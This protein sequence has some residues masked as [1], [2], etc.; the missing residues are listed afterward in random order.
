MST[1][2]PSKNGNHQTASEFPNRIQQAEAGERRRKPTLARKKKS[3]SVKT[4]ADCICA[5]DHFAQDAGGKLYRYV[6]GVY[7]RKAEGFLKAEVKRLCLRLNAADDWSTRLASEVVEYIRVDA[8]ELWER[9]PIDVLNVKNGLLRLRDRK[10]LPHSPEHLSTVQLHFDWDPDAGCPAIE[11]FVGEVFPED[12]V[13]LAWEIT[14][15][16]MVPDVS[17]QKAILLTG[18][19]AN[20][21]STYLTM[22]TAFIGKTNTAGVALHSLEKDKFKVSRLLGKLANICPDLPSEHLSGTSTFKAIV[23]GDTLDAEYK[24]RD[25]FDFVPFSRLVFS[26][27]HPPRSQD[28]SHAFF[29]RWVVIPFD[30]T[31]EPSEQ[32]PRDVLDARLAAPG[33]LAG[34]LNKAL[35]ARERLRRQGGFSEPPSVQAAWQEFH[36]TTDPLAVWLERFTIDDPDA[37]ITKKDLRLAYSSECERRGRPSM[38]TKQFGQA[39]K[40]L[41]PSLQDGQRVV[42]SK[43]QWCYVGIGFIHPSEDDTRDARDARDYPGLFLSHARGPEEDQVSTQEQSRGNRVHPVHRVHCVSD[44]QHVWRDETAPDGRVRVVCSKCSKFQGYKETSDNDEQ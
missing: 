31:L 7:K 11:K 36:A 29:R 37:V 42:N 22:L 12:A 1:T 19:G 4:L 10:L 28:A 27:N 2:T 23:G 41:R 24:F 15:W 34:L 5:K 25:S 3:V 18:E 16:L 6:K 40:R 13:D 43:Y 39:L 38:N 35:D 20:G 17:I 21:K 33:E 8:P 32:I 26:A 44:C 30:R 9:P 14:G